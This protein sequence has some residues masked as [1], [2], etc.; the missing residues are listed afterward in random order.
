M[1]KNLYQPQQYQGEGVRSA[2]E[3]LADK[4]DNA[5]VV[6]GGALWAYNYINSDTPNFEK[7]VGYLPSLISNAKFYHWHEGIIGAL[8]RFCALC[9]VDTRLVELYI[10]MTFEELCNE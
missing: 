4:Y 5:I 3:H 8:H 7:F 2:I 1:N 10:G 9:L 6:F